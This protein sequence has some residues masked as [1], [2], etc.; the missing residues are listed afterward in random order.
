MGGCSIIRRKNLELGIGFPAIPQMSIPTIC[1]MDSQFGDGQNNPAKDVKEGNWNDGNW[2]SG[3]APGFGCVENH[4]GYSYLNTRLVWEF[5]TIQNPE[6]SFNFYNIFAQDT[7][8]RE[9]IF[10]RM[11][12][13]KKCVRSANDV[14]WSSGY[15]T[16]VPA[17]CIMVRRRRVPHDLI[18][19]RH[20]RQTLDLRD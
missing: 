14:T 2:Q 5:W 11:N 12:R 10:D 17:A 20:H 16:P 4:A 15:Y 13:T 7:D 19:M 8:F 9:A 18:S 1:L 6:R 3:G